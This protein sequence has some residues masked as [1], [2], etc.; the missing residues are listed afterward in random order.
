M[1]EYINQLLSYFISNWLR[2][3]VFNFFNSEFVHESGIFAFVFLCFGIP[4]AI[5]VLFVCVKLIRKMIWGTK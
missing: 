5:S 1:L 4:I 3:I 2:P